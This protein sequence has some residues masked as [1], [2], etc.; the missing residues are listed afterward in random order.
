MN[1]ILPQYVMKRYGSRVGCG[2]AASHA[3]A[4]CGGI[5]QSSLRTILG[6]CSLIICL[7]VLLGDFPLVQ[8]LSAS[9][10]LRYFSQLHRVPSFRPLPRL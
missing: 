5:P 8:E 10:G 4:G 6:M 7:P 3:Q 9:S 1:Y 2:D